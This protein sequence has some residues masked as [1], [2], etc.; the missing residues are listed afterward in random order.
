MP[1]PPNTALRL[2]VPLF[3]VSI[4]LGATFLMLRG[5]QQQG[6]APATT[7]APA[8]PGVAPAPAGANPASTQDA[9]KQPPA[10]DATNPAFL[11][12]PAPATTSEFAPGAKF[13]ARV[14]PLSAPVELGDLTPGGPVDAKVTFSTAGAGIHQLLLANHFDSIEE[15]P[16]QHTM[17]QAEHIAEKAVTPMAALALEVTLPGDTAQF[18][19]L[20]AEAA[21]DLWRPLES[22]G[23]FEAIIVDE[24]DAPVMRVERSYTLISGSP[25]LELHQKIFN[26]SSTPMKVRWFQTGPVDLPMDS[27]GYG[28]DK[29]RVR[30]GYLLPPRQDPAQ[31]NVASGDFQDYRATVIAAKDETLWPNKTSVKNEY[32]L[33]WLGMT[34]RYFGAACFPLIDPKSPQ[35]DRRFNWVESVTRVELPTGGIE[36][37]LSMRLA[38]NPLSLAPSGKAGDWTDLPMGL[39]AGPLSRRELNSNKTLSPLGLSGLVIYSFG[40][41]CGFCTFQPVTNL[42]LGALH[43]LHDYVTFDWSL[44]IILMVVCVR[45]CLHPVTR[46]SQIR[47]ARFGKQMSAMGPKQKQIQEK[48]KDDPTR[49]QTEM[50]KLWAEEGINPAGALGCL[51]GLL[52]T[53]IWYALSAMLFFAVELRHQHGFFGVF[54]AVLPKGSLVWHFMG[55]LAEP[56]RF[57]YF[58]HSIAKLPLLGDISSINILPLVL[59]VVFFLQQ[60]YLTPPSTGNMTPEQEFQMKLTRGLMV[61]GFPLMMYNAPSGLALYF[62]ANSTLGILESRHIRAHMDKHGMLDLDKIR[63]ERNAKRAGKAQPNQEGFFGRLQRLAEEKQREAARQA[64]RK[65]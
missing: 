34:N 44:A 37:I 65:K 19:N 64:A 15:N 6:K 20:Y 43:F 42:L 24:H 27:A 46:W 28:G 53:P 2:A 51:P 5:T 33:S 38:S 4:G 10:P 48:Y 18:V 56:D 26:L 60:K 39:Y 36:P 14:F 21:G 58:G 3:I 12:N 41:P 31:A 55:D 54:Q 1:K 62:I 25:T 45:T 29:R 7:A 32:T 16:D 13:H 59:G 57:L 49:L 22:P 63:A 30:F 9:T 17:V 8:A 52:Q 35:I 50:R 23:A 11:T 47:M 40:G 61:F